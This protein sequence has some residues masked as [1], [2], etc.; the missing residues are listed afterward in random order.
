MYDDID[1]KILVW[2]TE[3]RPHFPY[4]HKPCEECPVISGM[5]RPYTEALRSLPEDEQ[6]A[7][8]ETWFC[9]C[10]PGKACRGNAALLGIV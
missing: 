10:Q 4:A 1:P 6:R 2:K 9:H 3:G 7:V 5:Y 8:S